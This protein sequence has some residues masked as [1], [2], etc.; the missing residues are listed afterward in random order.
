VGRGLDV[1][2]RD[3]LE[4]RLFEAPECVRQ[5]WAE[6][7]ARLGRRRGLKFYPAPGRARQIHLTARPWLVTPAQRARM[8]AL[9]LALDAATRALPALAHARPEVAALLP[10]EPREARW[11]RDWLG[12]PFTRP[13]TLLGRVDA[14]IDLGARD[15]RSTL[16]VLET[17]MVGVGASYYSWAA[18][19]SVH[20]VMGPWLAKE[21]PARRFRPDDD[22]LDLILGAV[23]DHGEKIGVPARA[24]CLMEETCDSG[25]AEFQ[26]M[27]LLLRRRGHDVVVADPGEIRARGGR[28]FARDKAVDF[29]YRDPTA[30]NLLELEDEGRDISGVK[31]AFRENRVVSGL[32]GEFDQ[33]GALEVF[34]TPRWQK[35]FSP[36]ARRLIRAHVSWT[37]VLRGVRTEDPGGKVVDLPEFTRRARVRLVIKPNRDYGGTGIHFGRDESEGSWDRLIH[38]AV[39]ENPA[40]VV[41]ELAKPVEER[42]PAE[43]GGWEKR[44]TIGGFTATRRG[45]AMLGRLSKSKVVNITRD[46]GVAGILAV[47]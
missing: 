22:V 6:D 26:T 40:W 35:S 39:R 24:V 37:R 14:A 8:Q 5:R 20:E 4:S 11:M 10:V 36:A 47:R 34:T 13:Q 18:S 42:Y 17:N 43:G 30:V 7:L 25:P 9:F 33:K 23:R 12:P 3:A 28:L 16:R 32:A 38:R 21:F 41:Q 1:F 45:L 44:V 46:G 29:L 31:W 15:W 27:A 2:G 19:R